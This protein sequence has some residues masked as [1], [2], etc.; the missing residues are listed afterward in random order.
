MM[1]F[2]LWLLL[3]GCL[4]FPLIIVFSVKFWV[5]FGV[6]HFGIPTAAVLAHHQFVRG[7][8]DASAAHFHR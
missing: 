8:F 7:F 6:F 1:C 2:L 4:S 3:V 5:L